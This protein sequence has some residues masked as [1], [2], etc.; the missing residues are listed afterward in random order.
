MTRDFFRSSAVTVALVLGA[1]LAYVSLEWAAAA[2]ALRCLFVLA[3]AGASW[4]GGLWHGVLA[5]ALSTLLIFVLSVSRSSTPGQA[6]SLVELGL[7]WVL[8]VTVSVLSGRAG[9]A[10][11]QAAALHLKARSQ[12][13][14][15]RRGDEILRQ[16]ID[17]SRAIV[18]VKNRN[19]IYLIANRFCDSVMARDGGTIVG[20]GD[21]DLLSPLDADR[22]RERDRNV[23]ETGVP[24]ESE[25]V[26]L[27]GDGPHIF[28]T[29]R[30]PIRVE[31]AEADAVGLLAYD[32]TERRRAE[33]DLKRRSDLYAM[34]SRTNR[35][36]SRCRSR[37]DL[38]HELCTIAVETGRFQFAWIG[39]CVGDRLIMV[40]S[41]GDDGGY[42]ADLVVSLNEDDPRSH[43]PSGTAA[44]TGRE[45][46]VN[47]FLASAAT[48]LWHE[49]ARRVGFAS[50][51]ALPLKEGDRVVG[52]LTVYASQPHFFTEELV[53]TLREITPSVSFAL[54]GFV[55]EAERKRAEEAI[56][57]S[58]RR[59]SAILESTTDCFFSLDH[60]W[61][62]TYLN[63][64]AEQ[65]LRRPREEL[66]DQVC[67]NEFPEAVGTIFYREY[68]RAVEEGVPVAFE[69]YYAALDGWYDVRA[70]PTAEG[71]AVYVSDITER[72]TAEEAIRKAEAER[73]RQAE[74]QRAI[75]NALPAHVALI[76]REGSILEVNE[77]WRRFA[78]SNSAPSDTAF[79]G[80]NYLRV[81]ESASGEYGSD[82]QE[83]AMGLRRLLAGVL[84]QL[85]KEYPCHSPG[86]QRWF[87]LMA[88]PLLEDRGAGAVIM[89]I[90]VTDRKLAEEALARSATR[91]EALS[92]Q[93]LR[94]QE[95][96]RRRIAREL[97]DQIGQAL[98]ALKINIQEARIGVADAPLRLEESLGIVDQTLQQVRGMALD[99]RPS[100]LDD[101]GLIAALE[102]Y[103]SRH[104]QRTG[105]NGRVIADP[106][107]FHIDPEIETTCYRIVQEGLT[108]I[109]RHANASRF[110]VELTY[111]S[112][113]L[114]LVIRD[115][116]AGFDPE[117]TL[118]SA[119]R[120][121]SM[122]LA[123]MRER[124][125]LAGGRIAFVSRPGEGTEI[126]VEFTGVPLLSSG[127]VCQA[128][129]RISQ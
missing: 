50:S 1:G 2:G 67:W 13:E 56:R 86:E 18:S 92:R 8:A 63:P 39:E 85:V 45:F 111:H 61:H 55:A 31:S 53:E 88:S 3:A 94:A 40:E 90:D 74:I 64:R 108:N 118:R 83:V 35:A 89:H 37:A 42:M 116:G 32:I 62:F 24:A 120:G 75:L 119:S 27:L 78:E 109:A 22:A 17:H 76:D 84:P 69:A 103:V 117:A 71:L 30:F 96:E 51:A 95:A 16:L 7:F 104:A 93:L 107:E 105:L 80:Q 66:L 46:V 124:V 112:D 48:S 15:S 19:G 81:C 128:R 72:K 36:V 4:H 38:Y 82:G 21:A 114:C 58:E 106:P 127:A 28:S 125:E 41:A 9:S 10:G 77:S 59:I 65:V 11:R 6:S 25:E 98:T 12:R 26:V 91:L 79:V 60:E 5:T 43:G 122:G 20:R 126:Q 70:Y 121:M 123:G 23:L 102:W 97:H 100:M 44:R 52:V 33:Q 110:S 113:N 87:R 14:A 49:N 29:I 129:R 68:H 47:D 99:L 54:D 73:Q 115:D 57:E 34:L 101:L